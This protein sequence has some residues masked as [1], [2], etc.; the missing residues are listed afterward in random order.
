MA[1]QHVLHLLDQLQ[2]A[3]RHITQ[4]QWTNIEQ[5]IKDVWGMDNTQ[6]DAVT[7][8]LQPE[9]GFTVLSGPHGTGKTS[10]AIAAASEIRHLGHQVVYACPSN[11]AADAALAAFRKKAPT[12]IRAVRYVGPYH[13]LTAIPGVGVGI[14]NGLVPSSVKAAMQANPD[15][16][17]L[18]QVIAAAEKWAENGHHPMHTEAEEFVKCRAAIR[19]IADIEAFYGSEDMRILT[20]SLGMYFIQHEVDI[21]FTTCV[22]ADR[23]ALC[24]AFRPGA[25]FLDDAGEA[26][27]SDIAKLLNAYKES[28]RWLVMS[29]GKESATIV[30]SSKNLKRSAEV[31]S[32]SFFRRLVMD[33]AGTYTSVKLVEQFRQHP[34]LLKFHKDIDEQLRTNGPATATTSI[35]ETVH[36]F[37]RQLRRARRNCDSCYMAIDVSDIVAESAFF[38]KTQSYCD[39]EEGRI[40]VGLVR[41]LLAFKSDDATITPAHIGIITPFKGQQCLIHEMLNEY[42]V[43]TPESKVSVLTNAHN[44]EFEIVFISLC[45]RDTTDALAGTDKI[46]YSHALR[47][48]HSR[49]RQFQ[50]TCGNFKGWLEE[51][52]LGNMPR[53]SHATFRKLVLSLYRDN[54]IVSSLDIDTFLNASAEETHDFKTSHFYK[55]AVPN[56]NRD[57]IRARRQA[58]LLTPPV[59]ELI[60][61]NLARNR[62]QRA[63]DNL[64]QAAKD[65]AELGNP[66]DRNGQPKLRGVQARGTFPCLIRLCKQ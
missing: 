9:S 40:I 24:K 11:V 19:T 63:K 66:L 26:P 2:Y 54:A 15:T 17:F 44:C 21:I 46:A 50:V 8:I 10:I 32:Q 41:R 42:G 43:T 31:A 61:R 34:S 1:E 18:S 22:S 30:P 4:L 62:I 12:K 29:G 38:S 6:A 3:G 16:L 7:Q 39:A 59:T 37:F 48:Q 60:R 25:A 14:W 28:I 33:A 57:D 65:R 13:L 56:L 58:F 49:A 5:R 20:K 52:G 51:A 35:G 27:N 23:D 47:L 64:E 36:K 55:K 45:V 53:K